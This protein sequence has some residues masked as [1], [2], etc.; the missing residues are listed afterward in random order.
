MTF[1][2][3]TDPL[4]RETSQAGNWDGML[5]GEVSMHYEKIQDYETM[6]TMV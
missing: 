4:L 2:P 3:T 5:G 1:L 6:K